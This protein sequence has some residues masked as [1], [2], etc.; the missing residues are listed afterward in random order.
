MIVKA[1]CFCFQRLSTWTTINT[2]GVDVVIP[3]IEPLNVVKEKACIIGGSIMSYRY[4]HMN[5]REI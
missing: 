2:N 1:L 4:F 3:N 5:M